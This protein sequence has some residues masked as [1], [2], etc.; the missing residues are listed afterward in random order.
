[1]RERVK[2]VILAMLFVS[3]T[4]LLYVSLTLGIESEEGLLARIFGVSTATEEVIL[5][6]RSAAE[7]RVLAICTPDGVRMPENSTE[8]LEMQN[9][10]SAVYSE[11]VGSAGEAQAI[12]ARQ[13]LDLIK[14]PAVYLG[15]DTELP[16]FLLRTWVGFDAG[17]RESRLYSLLIAARGDEV[18]VAWYDTAAEEYRMAVTAAAVSQLEQACGAWAE[19]NAVFAFQDASFAVLADDEPVLLGLC[20]GA[21]YSVQPASFTQTGELSRELLAGFDFNPYLARVYE[22]GSDMVYVEGYSVLRA[23]AQGELTY[24]SGGKGQG[25]WLGLPE[26]QLDEWSLVLESVRTLLADLNVKAGAGGVYSLRGMGT[27]DNGELTLLFDMTLDGCPIEAEQT[28]AHVTVQ[29]GRVT[30]LR[31]QPQRFEE[32]GTQAVLPARQAAAALQGQHGLRL[33]VRYVLDD[34][35]MLVPKLCSTEIQNGVE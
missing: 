20:S 17:E 2:S 11:V 18:V 5:Q 16:M 25:I 13:Y 7:L 28:A 35:G 19:P 1:M 34:E 4:V 14:S 33:S 26:N 22:E 3:M 21:T 12:T 15:Y 24:T 9:T 23:S 31:M 27:S 29:D 10:L 6:P 8:K 30:Y 32:S